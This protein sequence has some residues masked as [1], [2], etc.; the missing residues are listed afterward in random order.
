MKSVLLV[1]ET[2]KFQ[3]LFFRGEL[4]ICKAFLELNYATTRTRNMPNYS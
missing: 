2:L 1:I 3:Q 4:K